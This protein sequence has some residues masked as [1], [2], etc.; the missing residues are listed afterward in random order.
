MIPGAMKIFWELNR[1]LDNTFD[2][3]TKQDAVKMLIRM[4]RASRNTEWAMLPFAVPYTLALI[5]FIVQN[6]YIMA[7]IALIPGFLILYIL[8]RKR[9]AALNELNEMLTSDPAYW[10]SI[11]DRLIGVTPKS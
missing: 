4:Y 8:E 1:V 10:G 2:P 6:W 11:R 7:I 9:V 5:V 3:I